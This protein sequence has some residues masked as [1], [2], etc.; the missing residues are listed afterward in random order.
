MRSRTMGVPVIVRF[1]TTFTGLLLLVARVHVLNAK[2]YG[3]DTAETQKRCDF[4]WWREWVGGA[5]CSSKNYVAIIIPATGRIYYR[6]IVVVVV[7]VLCMRVVT[8][9]TEQR[10]RVVF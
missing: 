8:K 1:R 4:V 6:F 7:V 9:V 3:Q 5:R 10:Q 2:A